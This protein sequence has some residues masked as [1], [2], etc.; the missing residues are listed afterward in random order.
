MFITYLFKGRTSNNLFQYFAAKILE[1]LLNSKSSQITI[2][3]YKFINE[4]NLNDYQIKTIIDD[5]TFKFL[6]TQFKKGN[7][8]IINNIN[9]DSIIVLDGYFQWDF[10]LLEN[11]EF[12]QS[13]FVDTNDQINT[14]YN[15]GQFIK[16]INDPKYINF[17]N[18][19]DL[20]LHL[21]LD[22]FINEGYNSFVIHPNSYI[23]IIEKIQ[24]QYSFKNIYVVVD[25]LRKKYEYEYINKL[26]NKFNI[27]IL[28]GTLFEDFAKIY[29][30]KNILCNN[31][32]FCW[33]P[34]FI[35]KSKLNWMPDKNTCDNQS[36]FKINE[37]TINYP[38]E[39]L[40]LHHFQI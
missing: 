12:I 2:F 26:K 15:I 40:Y 5:F 23:D 20:V 6:Y 32:T 29:H 36:F 34:A 9:K 17:F 19:D 11:K 18:E 1:K 7:F 25:K 27:I 31:S 37:N 4:I 3:E 8:N 22:D 38:I 14:Q 33:I 30:A 28:N 10:L 13:L 21:R 39:Y 35:G 16:E 24:K